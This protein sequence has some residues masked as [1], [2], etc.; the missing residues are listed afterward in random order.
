[1]SH[2]DL[3]KERRRGKISSRK[4]HFK[5]SVSWHF[6]GIIDEGVLLVNYDLGL[7]CNVEYVATISSAAPGYFTNNFYEADCLRRIKL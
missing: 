1:L 4:S 6:L 3:S 5:V 7:N 2:Y